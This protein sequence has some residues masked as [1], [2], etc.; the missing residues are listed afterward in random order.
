MIS[1]RLLSGRAHH[2]ASL[3]SSAGSHSDACFM[4]VLL[5]WPVDDVTASGHRLI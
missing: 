4:A 1:V 5:A 3:G 2:L